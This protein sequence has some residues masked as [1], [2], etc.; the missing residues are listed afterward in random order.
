MLIQHKIAKKMNDQKG[1]QQDHME[2]TK[3]VAY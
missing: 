2:V 1:R 3:L